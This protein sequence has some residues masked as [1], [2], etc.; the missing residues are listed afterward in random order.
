[1][2]GS[3]NGTVFRTG[4]GSYDPSVVASVSALTNLAYALV[5][6]VVMTMIGLVGGGSCN[7]NPP[8]PPSQQPDP[9]PRPEPPVTINLK[10]YTVQVGSFKKKEEANSFAATL[11]SKNINNYLLKADGQLLV[12]V[13]KYVSAKR[14]ARMVNT[15]QSYGIERPV[16][17]SPPKKTKTQ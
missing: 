13:G 2:A 5:L 10:H 17:L 3:Q 4:A 1:M 12:C 6:L 14:A 7:P 8:S 11:R 16:V 15:L 9:N